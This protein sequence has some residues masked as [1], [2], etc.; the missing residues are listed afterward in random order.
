MAVL[1]YTDNTLPNF[2]ASFSQG[3]YNTLNIK[4]F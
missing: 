1:G 2:A 3:K 4:A